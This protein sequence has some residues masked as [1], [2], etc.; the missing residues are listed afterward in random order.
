MARFECPLCPGPILVRSM[1]ISELSYALFARARESSELC[2]H[3]NSLPPV[4][5]RDPSTNVTWRAHRRKAGEAPRRPHPRTGRVLGE[6][7]VDV[8]QEAFWSRS[9]ETCPCQR[10]KGQV[11]LGATHIRHRGRAWKAATRAGCRTPSAQAPAHSARGDGLRGNCVA[12][13]RVHS[14]AGGRGLGQ[15][16]LAE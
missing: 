16:P 12:S 1:Y 4:A 5:A 13:I 2:S 11:G 14:L 10:T 9:P 8:L 7:G 6:G 3:F 15:R